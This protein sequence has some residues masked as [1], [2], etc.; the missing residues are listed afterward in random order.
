MKHVY[1]FCNIDIN[2]RI[3]GNVRGSPNGKIC[4]CT[5]DKPECFS[6]ANDTIGNNGTISKSHG[7]IDQYVLF[8]YKKTVKFSKRGNV[9][10]ATQSSLFEQ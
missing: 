2:S 5:I 1:T 8:Y 7:G 6:A 10:L 9:T 3:I 4:K